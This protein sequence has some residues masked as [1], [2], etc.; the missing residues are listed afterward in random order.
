MKDRASKL[1]IFLYKHML[2][3]GLKKYFMDP[4]LLLNYN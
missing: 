1:V 4:K 2:F 3:M